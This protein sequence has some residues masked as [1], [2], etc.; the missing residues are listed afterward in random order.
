M[1]TNIFSSLEIVKINHILFVSNPHMGIF[2]IVQCINMQEAE[3]DQIKN[4]IANF[5]EKRA[6]VPYFSDLAEHDTFGPIFKNLSAEQRLEVETIIKDYITEKIEGMTKTKWG[7]LFK[8]FFE[9]FPQMFWDFRELN[10]EHRVQAPEFQTIGK[11]VEYEM[12]KL[13]GILTEKMFKQEKWL[14]KVVWSFYNIVYT[15][16]PKYSTVQ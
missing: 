3:V 16:F 12:F 14:D 5:E 15:F 6:Y 9:A 1:N 11:Q 8:R 7:Q 10:E 2:F 13:E 4:I